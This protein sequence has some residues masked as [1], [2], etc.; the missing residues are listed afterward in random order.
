MSNKK[1]RVIT[2][3][4]TFDWEDCDDV[5]AD[6]MLEDGIEIKKKGVSYEI[7]KDSHPVLPPTNE[8]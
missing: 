3:A 7:I 6:L 2:I 8:K 4:I 1:P 5:I